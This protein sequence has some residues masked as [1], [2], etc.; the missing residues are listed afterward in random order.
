M[1][2]RRQATSE[3]VALTM[4]V[5]HADRHIT[6]GPE[7]AH[8]GP[9]ALLKT[10]DVITIDAVRG[11]ISV[12]LS[13][14]QLAA[15]KAEWAGPRK[16]DYA[17]GALWKYAQLVGGARWGAVTHPGAAKETHIYMDQ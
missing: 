14:Q 4:R 13:E 16:T 10:G 15:R 7:A 17:S 9:I 6:V 11:E 3:P 2:Q 12:D 1:R 8:G 5:A